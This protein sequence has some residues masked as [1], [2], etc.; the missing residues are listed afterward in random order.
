MPTPI[1]NQEVER[2]L[3]SEDCLRRWIHLTLE[4][5]CIRIK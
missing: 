3:L 4:Q 2:E 5:R 1:G